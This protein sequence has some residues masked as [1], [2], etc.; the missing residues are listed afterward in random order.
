MTTKTTK[1]NLLVD[2]L[3]ERRVFN[4]EYFLMLLYGSAVDFGH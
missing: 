1:F 3:F 4:E 2:T